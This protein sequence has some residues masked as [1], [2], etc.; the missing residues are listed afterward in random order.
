MG[1]DSNNQPL[2]HISTL[3]LSHHTSCL[4]PSKWGSNGLTNT[5]FLLNH[6]C[7]GWSFLSKKKAI[8]YSTPWTSANSCLLPTH[9]NVELVQPQMRRN[10]SAALSCHG[11]TPTFNLW[12]PQVGW[13]LPWIPL[14]W[15]LNP[16]PKTL[17]SAHEIHMLLKFSHVLVSSRCSLHVL[18]EMPIR[19]STPQS[20]LV[21]FHPQW[22]RDTSM[23]CA[24]NQLEAASPSQWPLFIIF[25]QNHQ[26]KWCG[27]STMPS[28]PSPSHHHFYYRWYVYHSQ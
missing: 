25:D 19:C 9:R 5:S 23:S 27:D 10:D 16:H 2:V 14:F 20:M 1:W 4:W 7:W 6:P 15:C 12:T 26:Q 3:S 17:V 22:H 11:E 8:P 18:G 28:A 24:T 21:P 13:C